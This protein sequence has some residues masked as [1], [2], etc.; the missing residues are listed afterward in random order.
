MK[1]VDVEVVGVGTDREMA[2][3]ALRRLGLGLGLKR[4]EEAGN[5]FETAEGGADRLKVVL[6]KTVAGYP[7]DIPGKYSS[8]SKLLHHTQQLIQ[9][10]YG[11]QLQSALPRVHDITTFTQLSSDYL[12]YTTKYPWSTRNSNFRR[13]TEQQC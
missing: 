8:M 12:L 1:R 5:G 7:D 11:G 9:A 6:T 4:V 10:R 2:Y 13:N 3:F